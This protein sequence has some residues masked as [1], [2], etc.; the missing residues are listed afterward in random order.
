VVTERT[1]G[2]GATYLTVPDGPDCATW[3]QSVTRFPKSTAA[4]SDKRGVAV[5]WKTGISAHRGPL[6]SETETAQSEDRLAR[7][8]HTQWRPA[9]LAD[10]GGW[11]VGARAHAQLGCVET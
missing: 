1:C 7:G 10:E 4:S 9:R 6:V 8:P 11:G 3:A 2:E 5:S